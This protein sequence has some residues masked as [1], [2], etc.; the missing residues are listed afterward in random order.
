[1]FLV[2]TTGAGLVSVA[3]FD[4]RD[5]SF[6]AVA[7]VSEPGFVASADRVGLAVDA[8][9]RVVVSWVSKPT[10]YEFEQVVARVLALDATNK[11]ISPLTHTFFAFIN[12]AKAGIRTLQMNPSMT[13]RQILIA[14]KGEI[15][16]QNKPDLGVN[17]TREVNL[18]TV[19]THPA[20]ADD[21]TTPVGGGASISIARSGSD[22]VVTFTGTLQAADN[23]NG[24]YSDVAGATSPRTIPLGANAKK[25]WR[26]KQ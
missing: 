5:A 23:V 20:P 12:T 11:T 24:P 19:F 22:A 26:A 14:A 13:T 9:S 10:D 3:V 21:P 25:F 15:N 1:V 8:L 16:L 2:G 7:D 18:Y 17:S 6:V 4:S